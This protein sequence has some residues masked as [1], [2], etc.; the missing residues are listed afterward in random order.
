M[1]SRRSPEPH[2][3]ADRVGRPHRSPLGPAFHAKI[4]PF[5]ALHEPAIGPPRASDPPHGSSQLPV[6]CQARGQLFASFKVF[7]CRSLRDVVPELR[8]VPS[9]YGTAKLALAGSGTTL[10]RGGPCDACQR[11]LRIRGPAIRPFA[12]IRP[13]VALPGEATPKVPSASTRGHTVRFPRGK[14]QEFS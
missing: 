1:V 3:R 10:P 12:H 4:P 2:F 7:N 14:S 6:R 8:F 5:D 9:G 11:R 13:A